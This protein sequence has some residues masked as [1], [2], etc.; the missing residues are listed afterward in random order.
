[1]L[2]FMRLAACDRTLGLRFPESV[3]DA[4]ELHH[5]SIA[6]WKRWRTC[7]RLVNSRTRLRCEDRLV[8]RSHLAFRR[9]NDGVATFREQQ[10]VEM[11]DLYVA[12]L[13][14]RAHIRCVSGKLA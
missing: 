9:T 13:S 4:L 6:E 7:V 5:L 3:C 2:H 11:I 12:A 14:K 1:M 10:D 8:A